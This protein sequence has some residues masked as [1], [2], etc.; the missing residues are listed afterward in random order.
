MKK[1][2]VFFCLLLLI[3]SFSIVAITTAKKPDEGKP[4]LERRVYIHYKRSP[5][6]PDW[7]TDKKPPKNDGHSDDYAL[8]GKG[9]VWWSSDLPLAVKINPEN[10]YGLSEDFLV[11]AVT[12]SLTEWDSYTSSDLFTSSV[13]VDY[14]A[15][16]D[17]EV[18]DGQNEIVFGNYGQANVIAVTY[19]WGY[20]TGKPSSRRIVEFDIMLDTDFDWGDGGE[21]PS[22]MDV[23]NIV[24]HELGH[25]I[26]LADIYDCVLETMYGYSGEGDIVKRDLYDGDIAGLR[27]LYGK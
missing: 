5:G 25:G 9:I 6:K 24:T 2:G 8:L 12:S 22:L 26:G 21:Y 23:Q 27:K 13:T 7:V 10:S 4:P 18:P 20:F 3:S 11:G 15:S 17:T 14:S 19:T 1:A 16:F